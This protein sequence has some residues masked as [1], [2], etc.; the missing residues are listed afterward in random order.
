MDRTV[1]SHW[2]MK[3]HGV[4]LLHEKFVFSIVSFDHQGFHSG[5][6]TSTEVLGHS[7]DDQQ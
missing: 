7:S 4:T 1:S 2:K 5:E 3:S 6:D